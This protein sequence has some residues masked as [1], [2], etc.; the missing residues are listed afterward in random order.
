MSRVGMEDY[1]LKDWVFARSSNVHIASDRDWFSSY[2]P[3]S[4]YVYDYHPLFPPGEPMIVLGIGT[5]ML[6]VRVR[7]GTPNSEASSHCLLGLKNVLHVPSFIV[8]VV[9]APILDNYNFNLEV[10]TAGLYDSKTH[11]CKGLFNEEPLPHLRLRGHTKDHTSLE[12][13]Q[14]YIIKARWPPE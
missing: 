4:S 14:T 12:L 8:N 1:Y 6:D 7:A 2:T 9:G 5:V 10:G 13:D 3:F 11:A